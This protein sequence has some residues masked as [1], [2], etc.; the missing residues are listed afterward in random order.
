MTGMVRRALETGLPATESC[1][2][3]G[4]RKGGGKKERERGRLKS[5]VSGLIFTCIM[6]S[7]KIKVTT[8]SL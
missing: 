7:H 2:G 8:G 4:G 3:A 1:E 5:T 6:T